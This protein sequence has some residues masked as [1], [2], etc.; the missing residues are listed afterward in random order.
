MMTRNNLKSLVMLLVFFYSPGIYLMLNFTTYE[1]LA[2]GVL[3]ISVGIIFS[4][5]T[6]KMNSAITNTFGHFI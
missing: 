1:E 2:S 6:F 5:D 3:F 4:Y